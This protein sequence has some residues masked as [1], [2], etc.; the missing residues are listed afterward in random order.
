MNRRTYITSLA[1]SLTSA[2]VA[3]CTGVFEDSDTETEPDTVSADN[4]PEDVEAVRPL[5]EAFGTR[6]REHYPQARVG[7]T[8]N[9]E[10]GA[11]VTPNAS[12]GDELKRELHRIVGIYA[13]VASDY[14][15]V[16]LTI[17]AGGVQAIVP[18][19]PIRQYV[20]G[21]LKRNALEETIIIRG[22]E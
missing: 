7:I 3:G 5:A 15:P 20:S 14:E 9:G 22:S 19:T 13:D 8:P 12:S 16:S 4:I 11:A 6:L 10:L 18:R 21:D 17:E 2:S 1:A